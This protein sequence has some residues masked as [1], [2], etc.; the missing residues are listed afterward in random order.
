[1]TKILSQIGLVLVLSVSSLSQQITS[2]EISNSSGQLSALF[3]RQLQFAKGA[4]TAV[5]W[6]GQPPFWGGLAGEVAFTTPPFV[7]GNIQAGGMF[8]SG[9]SFYVSCPWGVD[10]NATF[11]NGTWIRSTLANGTYTYVL[12]G[13]ITGTMVLSGTLY[14]IQGISVQ[15]SANTGKT[16]FVGVARTGGGSTE[17]VTV[18]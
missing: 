2:V 17:V 1:M 7:F 5:G 8:R 4:I 18:P 13:E 6:D 14:N 11:V 16:Y 15:L 12:T 3:P 9:G 10:I